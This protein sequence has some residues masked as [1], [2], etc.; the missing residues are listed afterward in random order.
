MT[1]DSPARSNSSRA[2]SWSPSEREIARATQRKAIARK[3]A[4]VATISSVLVIGSLV[5]VVISS[6]GWAIF[7]QTFF[8]RAVVL[9]RDC[10][11]NQIPIIRAHWAW[12]LHLFR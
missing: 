8:D 5:L 7:H 12:L 6:P 1:N 4:L 3:H 10:D 2:L 9:L 11:C